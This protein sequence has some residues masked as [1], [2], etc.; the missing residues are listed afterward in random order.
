MQYTRFLSESRC[1]ASTVKREQSTTGY[2]LG[3]AQL[4]HLQI[5]GSSGR[6]TPSALHL[7]GRRVHT[8]TQLRPG[9]DAQHTPWTVE[10][11][12]THALKHCSDPPQLELPT[13]A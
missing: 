3:I 12:Q 9:R 6:V 4:K 13:P 8:F 2:G 11:I 7:L 10:F 5:Y 1:E